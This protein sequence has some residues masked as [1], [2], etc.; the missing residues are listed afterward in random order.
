MPKV[1][2]FQDENDLG[3][4]CIIHTKTRQVILENDAT[5]LYYRRVELDWT[6]EIQNQQNVGE[7]RSIFF[8]HCSCQS[9]KVKHC[10]NFID[11]R[12]T[13][14]ENFFCIMK[15]QILT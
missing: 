6:M 15:F 14:E 9:P 3:K 13:D 7:A 10:N 5:I 8:D 1:P 4:N 2:R 12:D 11:S